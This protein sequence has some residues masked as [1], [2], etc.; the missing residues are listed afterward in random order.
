MGF[1][2]RMLFKISL[3]MAW[4]F[5]LKNII[6]AVRQVLIVMIEE[7]SMADDAWGDVDAKL[8]LSDNTPSHHSSSTPATHSEE[9]L[10]TRNHTNQNRSAMDNAT[11]SSGSI[12]PPLQNPPPV[13]V[14]LQAVSVAVS[15]SSNWNI[16]NTSSTSTITSA[17]ATTDDDNLTTASSTMTNT[18]MSI[19]TNSIS[20]SSNN[21]NNKPCALLFF[22]IVKHFEDVALP[23]IHRHIVGPNRQCDIYLHTYNIS[24]API[25]KRNGDSV[26]PKLNASQ[27]FL[28]TNNVT[29]DTLDEFMEKRGSFLNHSRV[30]YHEEWGACCTSHDNMIKQWNSID[31]VWNLMRQHEERILASSSASLSGTNKHHTGTNSTYYQQ[32]GLFRT[33]VYHVNPVNIFDSNAS[34]PNWSRAWGLN[35]RLF[36]GSRANAAIWAD[37]F[38]FSSTFEEHYMKNHTFGNPYGGYHSEYIVRS[39]MKHHNISVKEKPVCVWRIRTRGVLKIQDCGDVEGNS[40]T[41]HLLKFAPPGYKA[42][43][44]CCSALYCIFKH[45]S[46]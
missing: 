38:G 26:A 29:M 31:G 25:N 7:S 15:V 6:L 13:P 16:S 10:L 43:G 4:L 9:T 42:F 28:L 5:A 24:Q 14:P 3:V 20:N 19:E 41:T 32:V 40:N 1:S 11:L 33:D 17:S 37:R 35:D 44:M 45:Y 36:Y 22:G 18:I 23:A 27:V 30:H 46:N 12:A 8:G 2:K 39:L 34:V 21:N